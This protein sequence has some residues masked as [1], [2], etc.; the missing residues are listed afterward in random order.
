MGQAQEKKLYTLAEYFALDERS[1]IRYEYFNGEIFAM[2]GTTDTHNEIVFNTT[3]ALRNALQNQPCK[4]YFENIKLEAIANHYYPY[5]DVMVTCDNRDLSDHLI[6]RYPS[7]LIEVLSKSTEEYDRGFKLR[8]YKKIS[9]LQYYLLIAQ[10]EC[11]VELYSRP[12]MNVDLWTYQVF[13][14]INDV[15]IF[16]AL[17][18]EFNLLQIY[19][20]IGFSD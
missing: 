16:P 5:P 17:N 7:I 4:V 2:A 1:E 3:L 9:T 11:R 13:E 20:G 12:Q 10:Y 14:D 18:I 19:E 15:I 8:K 6:K